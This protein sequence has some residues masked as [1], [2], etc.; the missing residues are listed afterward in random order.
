VVTGHG[1]GEFT[2]V[3]DQLTPA[4]VVYVPFNQPGGTSLGTDPVVRVKVVT[5]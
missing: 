4:G 2:A 1:Q 5:R 3:F